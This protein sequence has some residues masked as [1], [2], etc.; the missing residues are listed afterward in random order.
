MWNTMGSVTRAL[1]LGVPAAAVAGGL[2]LLRGLKIEPERLKVRHL[3]WPAGR[4]ARALEGVKLAQISDLH[5]GGIGWRRSTMERAV[6]ACNDENPD[7]VTITGDFLGAARGVASALEIASALRRDLPR[8][9]VLG[10]HDHVYGCR[11]LRALLD[12]LA[13]MGIILLNNG[14]T[15]VD[16]PSGRVWFIGVDDGYSGR[17]DLDRAMA[18]V[19]PQ[20]H[21]R[22]L[23]THYPNVADRLPGGAFQLAL[24][25]HSHAGQIRLPVLSQ[26]I[27]EEHARTEYRYGGCEV[28]GNRLYV[29]SGLG[30]SSIPIR[31]RNLPEVAIHRFTA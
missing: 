15:A 5:V 29:T 2:A 22:I 9:A 11:P 20:D 13:A 31:F 12:G 24:A 1:A 16:V 6:E 17:D 25:G 28:N 19:G 23:L 10:N 14:A 3:E 7:V 26:R 4:H 21:P 18:A 30:M 27:S 8:L